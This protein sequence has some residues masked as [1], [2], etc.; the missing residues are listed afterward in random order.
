[1]E[2]GAFLIFEEL[3]FQEVTEVDH[4]VTENIWFWPGFALQNAVSQFI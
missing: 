4:N 1:M 2:L 3:K